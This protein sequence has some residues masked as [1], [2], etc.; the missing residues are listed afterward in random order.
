MSKKIKVIKDGPY[1]VTGGLKIKMQTIKTN[2]E[3]I[4]VEWEEGREISADQTYCLCRCGKS[5]T[6]P[7]CDGSHKELNF[8]GKETASRKDVKEEAELIEGPEVNLY[9]NEDLCAFA[10]FCDLGDRVWKLAKEPGEEAKNLCIKEAGLCPAG[11]LITVDKKTG[12]DI[13]PKFDQEIGLVQDP[14]E[15][16]SGPLWLKG[17]IPVESEDGFEYEVRNRQTLCRCGASSNKPF[18]DGSHVSCSFKDNL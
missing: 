11:R 16:C 18:C 15:N 17:G 1:E 8:D 12:E 10:R 4:S 2:E 6:M 3:G 5:K 13:E 9:D 14:P 7:F